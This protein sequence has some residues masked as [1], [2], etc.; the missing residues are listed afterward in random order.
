MRHGPES[1][2]LPPTKPS[3]TLLPMA[4][5]LAPLVALVGALL[6][7]YAKNG[8][9]SQLGLVAFLCGLLATLMR[10]DAS[11]FRLH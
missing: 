11:S 6:Y 9:V 7:G 1:R 8:K 4:L 5:Y 2:L 10:M 3:P